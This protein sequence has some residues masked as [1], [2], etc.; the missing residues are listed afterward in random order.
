M[1]THDSFGTHDEILTALASHL[2]RSFGNAIHWISVGLLGDDFRIVWKSFIFT[3]SQ[4]LT[5]KCNLLGPSHCTPAAYPCN[6]SKCDSRSRIETLEEKTMAEGSHSQGNISLKLW[7]HYKES[8]YIF[9]NPYSSPPDISP[10]PSLKS[11]RELLMKLINANLLASVCE[12]DYGTAAKF[13][14]PQGYCAALVP[15]LQHRP[16]GG[17]GYFGAVVVV[18]KGE[19]KVWSELAFVKSIATSLLETSRHLKALTS[20]LDADM[21][22]LLI[23][24]LVSTLRVGDNNAPE[25]LFQGTCSDARCKIHGA[26]FKKR[27]RKECRLIRSAAQYSRDHAAPAFT[28]TATS[29]SFQKSLFNTA[30]IEI[31]RDAYV[32]KEPSV[33]HKSTPSS[34]EVAT[35]LN[36]TKVFFEKSFGISLHVDGGDDSLFVWPYE[37]G[38]FTAIGMYDLYHALKSPSQQIPQPRDPSILAKV[39]AVGTTG[40][41]YFSFALHDKICAEK[42]AKGVA[43]RGRG[44]ITSII[45]NLCDGVPTRPLTADKKAFPIIEIFNRKSQ[46]P[47]ISAHFT[48][49]DTPFLHLSWSFSTSAIAAAI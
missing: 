20:K 30:K 43:E 40:F 48:I 1:N 18:A 13:C 36:E 29:I 6:T 46:H 47:I 32:F 41:V 25:N 12:V 45:S 10:F 23:E 26:E 35:T 15:L 17:N 33:L 28:D 14:I 4:G 2:M 44:Q 21:P 11:K 34:N 24:A 37:P 49:T 39:L 8:P 27:H 22:S 9:V 31:E 19:S 7:E 3:G 16:E 5:E 38:V 42:L